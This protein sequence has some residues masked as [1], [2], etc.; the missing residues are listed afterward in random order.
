MHF[1]RILLK[2]SSFHWT[3]HGRIKH[4]SQFPRREPIILISADISRFRYKF[5][6]RFTSTFLWNSQKFCMD[7][8]I[9]HI[10]KNKI[11]SIA[12]KVCFVYARKGFWKFSKQVMFCF[13]II[14]LPGWSEI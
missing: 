1:S 11:H 9:S 3:K 6:I 13:E 10:I 12:S 2:K 4:M 5:K 7:S 8:K 14:V